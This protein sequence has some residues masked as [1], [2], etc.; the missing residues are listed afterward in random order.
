[1][2]KAAGTAWGIELGN[3][4]LKAVKLATGDDNNVEVLDYAVIEHDT[5]LT[6]PE[7][8]P[9]Q[10]SELINQSLEKFVEEHDISGTHIVVGIPGHSSFARFAK[11]PPVDKKNL[12][13]MVHY[14]A[15][16][17]IP[18]DID[19]VE[20]D[21][22]V[23]SEDEEAQELEI[24]I[25][26][27]KTD[28]AKR[29]LNP[30][31]EVNCLIN[32]V[33]M[34]PMALF[35]FLSYDKPE[36][37][38]SEEAVILI[39]IGAE[40]TDLIISHKGRVWQRSIKIGGNHFTAAV[41]KSF[42]LSFQKAENI[43]RT[44]NTSKHARQIFQAMRPVFSDL[45]AEIQRSLGFYSSGNRDTN[46]GEAIAMGNAMK[47]P[48]LLKFLQQSLSLPIRRMD[49]FDKSVP[50]E[51]ISLAEFS[52]HIPRLP[53]AYGLALQGIGEAAI[54]CNLLPKETIRLTQ[55]NRKH[56]WF[57]AA[58]ACFL[59]GGII[60]FGKAQAGKSDIASA[61]A[62]ARPINTSSSTVN[63]TNSA[64][65]DKVNE[66]EE[67]KE[68]IENHKKV[69][70]D[71]SMLQRLHKSLVNALPNAKHNP[72]QAAVYDAF[73]NGK[74]KELKQIPRNERKQV[75]IS[76]IK[77]KYTD[78]LSKSFEEILSQGS[79]RSVGGS[80]QT[81]GATAGRGG[82]TM[83]AGRG[84]G[85]MP[86]AG[87]YMPGGRQ[88]PT[89]RTTT[90]SMPSGR[91]GS[92]S[93]GNAMGSPSSSSASTNTSKEGF[94]VIIEGSTPHKNGLEFLNVPGVGLDRQTWGF[95]NRLYHFG[96]TDEQIKQ[97]MEENSINY[98]PAPENEYQKQ[99]NEY[100]SNLMFQS[101][102]G[103]GELKLDFDTNEG[104]YVSGV[105][106]MGQPVGIGV[107]KPDQ[108]AGRNSIGMGG[109]G[110]EGGRTMAGA[111]I[112]NR[113]NSQLPL[114]ID[115]YTQE[116]ISIEYKE[117]EEGDIVLENGE[118]V[119]VKHDYWFRLKMKIAIKNETDNNGEDN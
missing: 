13:N 72:E 73:L 36:L 117:N 74:L 63:E 19:D 17:Q 107:S 95:F 69:Y 104:S 90:P 105:S 21:W 38:A 114:L 56:K 45:A 83:P 12:P 10:R 113:A 86:G 103:S 61:E 64:K 47:L 3:S 33:Q 55:W 1:M 52:G 60:C 29:L 32:S 97:I 76:G 92:T 78:D 68:T 53:I 111:G 57:I 109:T 41:Q 101:Y 84:G 20:W 82:G 43:K 7:V 99:Q 4:A 23:L 51:D 34:G 37:A 79:S 39:D 30:Y 67:I 66:I 89:A 96:K 85:A 46:F 119:T 22:Q 112:G 77:T 2:A 80:Y 94:V 35:N 54:D 11:L 18:F 102:I 58:C 28:L 81:A 87:G 100:A 118:P 50:S 62:A 48:G 5:I 24:G 93:R 59:I 88:M 42:K 14:E 110:P 116:V 40:N 25:F 27:I 98:T 106:S 70:G 65:N 75:F 26:A 31:T 9:Q 6:S 108:N 91:L 15:Q 44:A 115:P 16:Q 8:T 71:R 49:T